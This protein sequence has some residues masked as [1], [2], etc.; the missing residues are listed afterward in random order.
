M[1][2]RSLSLCLSSEMRFQH[3]ASAHAQR[4]P[5]IPFVDV[6]VV[7]CC[8]F[9]R[10]IHF[11]LCVCVCVM[12]VYLEMSPPIL[13]RRRHC[14]L[15]FIEGRQPRN[16]THKHTHRDERPNVYNTRTYSHCTH[17]LAMNS[18]VSFLSAK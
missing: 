11:D 13:S 8:S 16:R 12:F 14:R 15:R 18:L 2:T 5:T 10:K 17:T 3:Q 9:L 7:R 4:T 6:V 1:Y